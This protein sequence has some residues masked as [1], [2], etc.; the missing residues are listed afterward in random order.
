MHVSCLIPTFLKPI[1]PFSGDF[2]AKKVCCC[3]GG[4][5]SGRLSYCINQST[6]RK[7]KG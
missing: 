7:D 4:T 2:S 6:E 3:S 1:Q 5:R